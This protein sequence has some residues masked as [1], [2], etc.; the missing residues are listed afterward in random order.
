[1]SETEKHLEQNL[2]QYVEEALRKF[3]EGKRRLDSGESYFRFDCD[4][5]YL[6]S[7]I[8]CAEVDNEMSS[9]QAWHLREKYLGLSRAENSG[10]YGNN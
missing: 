8:N 10:D 5:C 3:I 4:Y 7:S 1:M 6:Q 9:E 2:P